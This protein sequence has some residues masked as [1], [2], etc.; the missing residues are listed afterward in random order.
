MRNKQ[1]P[2]HTNIAQNL[3]FYAPILEYS[4]GQKPVW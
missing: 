2:N 3:N 4:K 1:K